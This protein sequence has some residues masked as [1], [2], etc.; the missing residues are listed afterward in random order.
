MRTRTSGGVAG[1]AG[2]SRR[3][4]ADPQFWVPAQNGVRQFR[5]ANYLAR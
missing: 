2:A 3:P 5:T 1:V 4:Y